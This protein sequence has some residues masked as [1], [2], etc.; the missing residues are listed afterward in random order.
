[1]MSDDEL[2]HLWNEYEIK[3]HQYNNLR[4]KYKWASQQAE[5]YKE[6][7]HKALEILE[8]HWLILRPHCRFK[9]DTCK[10][11]FSPVRFEHTICPQCEANKLIEKE[12]KNG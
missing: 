7:T 10:Q 12:K 6:A 8:E 4:E 1:M 2:T 9:C 5:Q 3:R 11:K